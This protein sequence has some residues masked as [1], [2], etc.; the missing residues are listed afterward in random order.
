MSLRVLI[1]GTCY[2]PT[3]D[4]VSE[5]R[6]WIAVNARLNPV[7][8]DLLLVDSN[9]LEEDHDRALNPLV[10]IVRFPDNIG[11]LARGGRDGWGR[12]FCFGLQYAL[13]RELRLR[14]PHRGRQPVPPAG[15][16]DHRGDGRRGIAV[17]SVP[18]RGTRWSSATGSRP[19]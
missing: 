6:R 3:D 8:C 15:D 4:K 7:G 5:L 2:A 18:V 1:F 11:H 10:G 16:A 13:E 19:A 9:S 17:S 12:A 14:R